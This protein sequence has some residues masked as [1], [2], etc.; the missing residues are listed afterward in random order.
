MSTLKADWKSTCWAC[1]LLVAVSFL[2][3][4]P[5]WKAYFLADDFA[6][7]SLYANRPFT[8]WVEIFAKDWTRGV[9]GTQM[10]EL[11]SMMAL[12]FWWDGRLWPFQPLGYH[13]TNILFHAASSIMVFLL[14]RT[15]FGGALG[16]S[17]FAGL[18]FSV[19]PAHSEAVSWISGRADPICTSFSLASLWT[20]VLYRSDR[21]V[22]LTKLS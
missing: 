18:L 4:A 3:Y 14:A 22:G 17:L 21:R 12:S 2:V 10:D 20:F 7:V 6:Y 1:A 5:V 11:R 19:H 8:D 15:L 9:W 16:A 13:I